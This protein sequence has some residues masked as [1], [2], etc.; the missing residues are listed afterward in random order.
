MSQC[1]ESAG[2][3]F[4]RAC[5]RTATS[6]CAT[7]A[8]EVCEEHQR[9]RPDGRT[10]CISCLREELREGGDVA[11]TGALKHDPYFFWSARGR[12]VLADDYTAADYA[13]FDRDDSSVN[14]GWEG[15]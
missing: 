9:Q 15:S 8:R 12:D 11:H 6:T 2:V 3:L 7:C 1:Q 14:E 10:A 4:R 5:E 13:L